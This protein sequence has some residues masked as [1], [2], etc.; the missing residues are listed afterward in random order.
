MAGRPV[1]VFVMTGDKAII[2]QKLF[3]LYN[4]EDS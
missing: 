2:A 3:F 1:W 4:G